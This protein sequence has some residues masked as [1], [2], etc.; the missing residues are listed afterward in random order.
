MC[1]NRISGNEFDNIIFC[2]AKKKKKVRKENVTIYGCVY[3]LNASLHKNGT[4]GEISKFQRTMREILRLNIV[5]YNLSKRS[6][7]VV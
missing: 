1:N 6:T 4:L 7:E 2:E 3:K 5:L